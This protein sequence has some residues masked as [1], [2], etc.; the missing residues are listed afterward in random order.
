MRL[1]RHKAAPQHLFWVLLAALMES[2]TCL[3][4]AAGSMQPQVCRTHR[5]PLGHTTSPR[6][7]H[8]APTTSPLPHLVPQAARLVLGLQGVGALALF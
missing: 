5:E 4:H 8:I 6:G 2:L 7:T 1:H 3:H